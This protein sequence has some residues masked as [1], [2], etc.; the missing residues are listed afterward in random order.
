MKQTV[1]TSCSRGYQC[2]RQRASWMR[3][4][5]STYWPTLG[6]ESWTGTPWGGVGRGLVW[7]P[8]IL[9]FQ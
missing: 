1:S 7:F 3:S 9:P 4:G 2:Q 6:R 5:P 8:V